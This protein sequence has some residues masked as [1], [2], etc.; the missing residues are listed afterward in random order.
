MIEFGIVDFI[1]NLKNDITEYQFSETAKLSQEEFFKQFIEKFV[2]TFEFE[3][4]TAKDNKKANSNNIEQKIA[5]IVKTGKRYSEAVGQVLNE[6]PEYFN[7][8]L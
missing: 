5:D 4:L 2:P 1:Q 3:E 6:H 8:E 7:F